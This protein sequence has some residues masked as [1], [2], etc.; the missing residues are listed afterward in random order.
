MPRIDRYILSQMTAL[1]GF[2]AL[3]LVSVYWL[4]RAVALFE[5]LIAD[6]QTAL[7]V[8]EF[9][10]L[11][12]PH[13][14][15][16]V[17]PVAAFTA[18]AYGTNRLAGESELVAMQ[19][20]GMSP[21]RLAR[22]VLVFGLMVALMVAILVH[23][24]VPSARARLSARQDA[25]AEDVAARFLRAGSFQFPSRG[26]T[27]FIREIGADGT[28]HDLLF[29]DSRDPVRRL[30]YTADE[31][32][33]V[34][35]DRGPVLVMASGMAQ[36]AR[37][38]ANGAERLA[39]TRFRDLT[40]DIGDLIGGGRRTG[41]DLRDYATH[42]LLAPDAALLEATGETPARA[43]L[44]AHLRLAQPLLSPVAAVLGFA[45]LLVGGYSR[46]GVGRQVVLSV[47]ALI[48]LQFAST[49]A[50]NAA[51]GD[52][53]LW[54]VVYLPAL[55]GAAACAAVLWLASAPRRR[56]REARG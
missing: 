18:A 15:A 56:P 21:W 49:A 10:A 24:L 16:L 53:S 55:I 28:M 29:D 47:L 33:I 31:A 45:L 40:F 36:E 4:N 32:R 7:V 9:T 27:L 54:P 22:P 5:Q 38:S 23:G 37:P 46:F 25:V 30:T 51:E 20:A 35:S 42:R 17:L 50:E 2:F 3:V 19:A 8:L 6:G 11:T 48:A 12:L 1:F 13:V 26:V 43:R 14:I 39:V 44:E 41:T 52:P 34:P